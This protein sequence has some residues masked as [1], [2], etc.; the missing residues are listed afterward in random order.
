MAPPGLFPSDDEVDELLASITLV[1]PIIDTLP[2][3]PPLSLVT[4]Q[5]LFEAKNP[6]YYADVYPPIQ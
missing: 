6:P 1:L 5:R 4:E 3:I 2:N